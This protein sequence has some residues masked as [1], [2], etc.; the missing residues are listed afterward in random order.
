MKRL[1]L[2]A[3]TVLIVGCG[4][5]V[6]SSDPSIRAKAMQ[7]DPA[8]CMELGPGLISCGAGDALSEQTQSDRPEIDTIRGICPEETHYVSGQGCVADTGNQ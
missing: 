8:K 3:A 2:V 7:F 6:H 4:P 1:I 5:A